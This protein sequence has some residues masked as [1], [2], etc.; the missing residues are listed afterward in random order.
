MNACDIFISYKSEDFNEAIW[1]KNVLEANNITCWMAP[2]SIP[3]GSN[4][5]QA[6]PYA[7]SNCRIFLLLV[8]NKIQQSVWVSKEINQAINEHKIIMP[9]VIEECELHSEFK[10]YLSDVQRYDVFKNKSDVIKKMLDEI[11]AI[12]E[13]GRSNS[14]QKV[15]HTN[16]T[17]ISNT[18]D[19]TSSYTNTYI[20][21]KTKV[22]EKQQKQTKCKS[23]YI[24]IL[25][26]IF[27]YLLFVP[28]GIIL[29]LAYFVTKS[30]INDKK[31]LNRVMNIISVIGSVITSFVYIYALNNYSSCKELINT[32]I[33]GFFIEYFF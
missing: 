14:T 10:F 22:T 3:G 32:S 30:C 23:N 21:G 27:T 5:A 24:F 4:Y 11:I 7:I 12:L 2:F 13:T 6:I 33:L 25:L 17:Y 16:D 1:L 28:A 19:A 18:T 20:P 31:R 26:I 9:Y 29:T 8:S 15:Y